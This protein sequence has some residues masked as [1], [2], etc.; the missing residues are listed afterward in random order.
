MSMLSRP[1]SNQPRRH[2]WALAGGLA[3][4]IQLLVV[5]AALGA[6]VPTDPDPD[7]E[8]PDA[9]GSGLV[10]QYVTTVNTPA[11]SKAWWVSVEFTIADEVE[12]PASCEI[13]LASYELPGPD[14]S[15]PQTLFDSDTGWFGAGTH[16]LTVDLPRDGAAAGCFAQY[17]FVFGPAIETLVFE[18]RYGDRQIRSR[19]EGSETCPQDPVEPQ[20]PPESGTEGG[21]GL[22]DTAMAPAS[23]SDLG[24]L[25]A[26]LLMAS[27]GTIGVLN[28]QA[29]RT[30]RTR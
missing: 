30:R 27:L 16:T 1:L 10:T 19:I 21:T 24:L 7:L 26:L 3:L 5:S 18:D 23:S 11:D 29:V 15:F 22:P 2:R 25:F 12:T 6:S 8:C 9:F 14:F 17:D 13:T 28:V 4:T 20:T